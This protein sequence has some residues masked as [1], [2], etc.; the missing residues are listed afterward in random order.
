M[1][2]ICVIGSG[3]VGLVTGAGM[4]ALGHDVACLDIDERKVN[5][6][7][8]GRV[9]FHEPGLEELLATVT[10]AGRIRFTTDYQPAIDGAEFIFIAVNTPAGAEGQA[11]LMA[12]RAAA[13]SLAPYLA[14]GAVII[15]KSTVPIGTGDLVS[16]LISRFTNVRFSVVSNPEFLR[17]G[18]AVADFGAPDRIVLGSDDRAAAERVAGLYGPV[19][20]PVLITDIRTAEMIKYA[21]N[22][23]LAT[24]IS[25]INEIA[26]VCERLGADVSVVARGMGYDRRIG[27]QFL[28]AGIGWGGSCFPKD[29]RALI[30][31]AAA[32]GSH[33]QLLRAV[34]DIN[35]DQRLGVVQKLSGFLGGLEDRTIGLL[36]LAFKPNT[37]DLRNAPAVELVEFLRHEGCHLRGY[38]PVA[39]EPARAVMPAVALCN[40]AYAMADGADALVLVTEWDEFQSLDLERVRSLMRTPV[41]I[42]GR[43]MFDPQRLRDLGFIYAGIGR[44]GAGMEPQIPA[45]AMSTA[46][47][48]TRELAAGS[49]MRAV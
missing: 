14:P 6:L 39:M 5:L 16:T 27:P 29:V 45:R 19:A 11:D 42:D 1:S 23:F 35:R 47:G 40:D 30:H 4:A 37:D 44:G 15:N 43:N 31:M 46:V 2:R 28:S 49:L 36:G 12:V 10:A 18:S 41:F 3:Y 17:E 32:S 26:A 7:R 24:K 48:M 21:S 22:A 38:D 13:R 33:P 9:P 8:E 25:F 34:V 20:A